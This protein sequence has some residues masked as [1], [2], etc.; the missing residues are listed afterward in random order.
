MLS[1]SCSYFHQKVI[2]V[3]IISYNTFQ[4]KQM[5]KMTSDPDDD[6]DLRKE[7]QMETCKMRTRYASFVDEGSVLKHGALCWHCIVKHY[8]DSPY[9]SLSFWV[10]KK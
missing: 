8:S 4:M 6:V 9:F 3:L 1:C 10:K 5:R 7:L 2:H